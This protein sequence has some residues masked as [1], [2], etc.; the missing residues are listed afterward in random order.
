[1][2]SLYMV[3]DRSSVT[4]IDPW[5]TVTSRFRIRPMISQLYVVARAERQRHYIPKSEA[6]RMLSVPSTAGLRRMASPGLNPDKSELIVIGTRCKESKL[7]HE[8]E[9]SAATLHSWRYFDCCFWNSQSSLE[10][11]LDE[12]LSFNTHVDNVY[13]AAHFHIRALRYIRRCIDD[14]TCTDSGLLDGRCTA[15]L[16]CNSILNGTSAGNLGKVQIEGDQHGWLK[17]P[18]PLLGIIK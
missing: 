13:K 15:R 7:S 2:G 18:T 8:G 11:T 14:E 4:W 3:S 16:Y 9:I 17:I 6:E 5:P 1:M 10:V 12:T